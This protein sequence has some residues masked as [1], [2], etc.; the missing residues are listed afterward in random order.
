MKRTLIAVAAAVGA[1][2]I[3]SSAGAV[4]LSLSTSASTYNLG[5]N[6]IVTLTGDTTGGAAALTIFVNTSY[7]NPGLVNGLGAVATQS[8]AVTSF[9]G[10]LPWTPANPACLATGCTIFNQLAGVMPLPPDPAVIIGTLTI[11]TLAAGVLEISTILTTFF[12]APPPAAVTVTIVPEPA[13]A[14]MLGLGLL[15]LALAGRRRA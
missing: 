3:A 2:G 10:F 9:G 8:A 13:T 1:L 7:D 12:G 4:A 15:G 11:P 5:D 6:I 14:G